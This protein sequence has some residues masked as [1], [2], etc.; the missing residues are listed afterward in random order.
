[1]STHAGGRLIAPRTV[2]PALLFDALEERWA[3]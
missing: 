2:G 1:M 3:A